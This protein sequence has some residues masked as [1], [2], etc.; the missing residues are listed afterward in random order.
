VSDETLLSE[1][2][3]ILDIEGKGLA[4]KALEERQFKSG[5]RSSGYSVPLTKKVI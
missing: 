4:R 2:L 3:L 1:V 5:G